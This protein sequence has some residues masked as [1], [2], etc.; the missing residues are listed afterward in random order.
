MPKTGKTKARANRYHPVSDV[1]RHLEE[2]VET[3][4]ELHELSQDELDELMKLV[5]NDDDPE[6]D[7]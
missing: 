4:D 3:L 1:E 2:W 7:R 6:D 5:A